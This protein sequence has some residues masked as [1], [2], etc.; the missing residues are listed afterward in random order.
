MWRR[1]AGAADIAGTRR[2][3]LALINNLVADEKG[4]LT[5]LRLDCWRAASDAADAV[6][7][8]DR[9]VTQHED[10]YDRGVR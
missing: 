10:R 6:P 2:T 3:L 9:V 1:E 8:H 7:G 4:A 5:S